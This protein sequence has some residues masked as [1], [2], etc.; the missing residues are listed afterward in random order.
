MKEVKKQMLKMFCDSCGKEIKG[1]YYQ[2]NL[3]CSDTEERRY[4]GF[5]RLKEQSGM[6]VIPDIVGFC[7]ECAAPAIRL[8]ESIR[9]RRG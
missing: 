5:A 8:Y 3:V 4:D 6:R 2:V 1:R 7:P 9:E